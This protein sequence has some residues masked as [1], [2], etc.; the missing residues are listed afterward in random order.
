MGLNMECFADLLGKEHYLNIL[1]KFKSW[2]RFF[3]AK[4]WVFEVQIKLNFKQ[5]NI[6]CSK[7]N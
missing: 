4:F 3:L 6:A 1:Q 5:R 2:L 7:K